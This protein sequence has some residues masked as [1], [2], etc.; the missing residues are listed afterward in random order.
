MAGLHTSPPRKK[1][2]L[3]SE[4]NNIELKKIKCIWLTLTISNASHSSSS[5]LGSHTCVSGTS[6]TNSPGIGNLF[7]PFSHPQSYPQT[8]PPPFL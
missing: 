2:N 7:Q 6:M 1:N 4:N 3:E 8:I 5:N